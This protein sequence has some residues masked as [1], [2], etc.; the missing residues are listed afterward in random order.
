MFR[1]V[2]LPEVVSVKDLASIGVAML[3]A[4]AIYIPESR[5]SCIGG[6]DGLEGNQMRGKIEKTE[7][8]A[9]QDAGGRETGVTTL[10]EKSALQH[11]VVCQARCYFASYRCHAK[12][13]PGETDETG[14]AQA[15]RS[16]GREGVGDVCPIGV[17]GEEIT[18]DDTC[19]NSAGHFV[20]GASEA[21]AYSADVQIRGHEKSQRIKVASCLSTLKDLRTDS[22]V[23]SEH[24][25]Q[26]DFQVRVGI[27]RRKLFELPTI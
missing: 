1:V 18:A 12:R 19:A 23:F 17:C 9:L 26:A 13:D 25:K 11:C 3:R 14:R 4:G 6:V 20:Q 27:S 10:L 16:S 2:E 15:A 21:C 24:L 7:R 5:Q 22:G 8:C